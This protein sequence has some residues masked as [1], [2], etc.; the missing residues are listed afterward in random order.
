ML[1]SYVEKTNLRD[2]IYTT[3]DDHINVTIDN[4]YLFITISVPSVETHLMFNEATQNNYKLSY[5]D[6]Y[7]DRPLISGR[8]V[9]VD[10]GSAQQDN[11]PDY[12][13]CAHQTRDR[14]DTPDKNINI[15][16]FDKLDLREYCVE[17]KGQR[18]PR[19]SLLR[20]LRRK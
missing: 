1:S 15:A 8:I 19:D 20:L 4:L 17:I 3:M 14:I 11:S 10:I 12:L 9:Q 2:I 7:T 13:L 5:D 18:Y 6:F 16:L